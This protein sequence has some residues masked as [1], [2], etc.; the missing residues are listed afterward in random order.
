MG[1]YR[2]VLCVAPASGVQ[3]VNPKSAP[4]GES[5]CSIIVVP[6]LTLRWIPRCGSLDYLHHP[7]SECRGLGWDAMALFGCAPKRPLNYLGSAGERLLRPTGL[8]SRAYRDWLDYI[9]ME[10]APARVPHFSASSLQ[11]L[12]AL[13][14]SSAASLI[15]RCP[16]ERVMILARRHQPERGELYDD[17]NS[18][19]IA[20]GALGLRRPTARVRDLSRR[21][22]P[23]R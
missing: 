13:S 12:R 21:K 11:G 23:A 9:V 17:E 4:A 6:T 5:D 22:R 8:S 20:R 7:L 10:D 1:T 3:L 18:E 19:R 14:S 2:S 16:V 15:W